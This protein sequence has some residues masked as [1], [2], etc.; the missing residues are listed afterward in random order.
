[1]DDREFLD[2]LRAQLLTAAG[3]GRAA[4]VVEPK[5]SPRRRLL[6]LAAAAVVAVAV[7][8]GVL[9]TRSTEPASA[10]VEVSV[11]GDD[12]IV[13]LTS[14][15]T[16]PDEI[17][18]EAKKAGLDVR[19]REEPVGPSNVGKF[20]GASNDQTPDF[21]PIDPQSDVYTGF[22]VRRDLPGTLDLVLGR[23]ARGGERWLASSDA[24][25]PGEVL[26]CEPLLGA[27]VD[28]VSRRIAEEGLDASWFLL[29]FPGPVADPSGYDD[30]SV[31][32]IEAVAVDEVRVTASEDGSWPAATARP[33]FPDGC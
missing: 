7:L 10:D 14:L 25:E 28:T 24:L 3:A 17:V 5:R 13:R 29:P 32:N 21:R 20:I 9:V 1:M 16:R 23:P 15:E 11:D 19:V 27:T 26:E 33:S 31:V 4:V 12:F 18:A 22:R 30:W 6:A 8:S 2:D